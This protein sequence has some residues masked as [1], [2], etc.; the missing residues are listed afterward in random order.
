MIEKDNIY[1]KFK[2]T[3]P[4]SFFKRVTDSYTEA[5]PKLDGDPFGHQRLQQHFYIPFDVEELSFPSTR[6][7]N[8]HRLY[9]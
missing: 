5:D 3:Q 9:G 6:N 8:G 1:L 7:S 4:I 2:S